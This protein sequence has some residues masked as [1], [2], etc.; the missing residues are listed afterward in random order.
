[1]N[2]TIPGSPLATLHSHMQCFDLPIGLISF[3]M[4]IL[5][6]WPIMDVHKGV[7]T[8][9]SEIP[10]NPRYNIIACTAGLLGG[11]S[12]STYSAIQCRA[13]WPLVLISV[14]KGF[15]VVWINGTSILATLS[16][17]YSS[18]DS[19]DAVVEACIIYTFLGAGVGTVGL[20]VIMKQGWDDHRMLIVVAFILV[21]FVVAA[22]FWHLFI[23]RR[24]WG[25]TIYE[26]IG[27]WGLWIGTSVCFLS[28]LACDWVLAVAAN[29]I[30]G[31]PS[32]ENTKVVAVYVVYIIA[33]LISL[34]NT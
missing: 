19:D 25:D 13:Y 31:V 7:L 3:L 5:A 33:T 24:N 4:H 2:T 6:Y 1:M 21:A 8:Y 18:M 17:L 15:F 16:H 9:I 10:E 12:I 30:N 34:A 28:P 22:I 14:W 29:N 20:G 26:H 32:G 23:C 11:L 27:I